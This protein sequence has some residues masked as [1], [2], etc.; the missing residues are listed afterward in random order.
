MRLYARV[1]VNI[2][3][4]FSIFHDYKVLVLQEHGFKVEGWVL[5]K[6]VSSQ[7]G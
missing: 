7:E 5:I 4:T 2:P 1:L 6:A 3:A